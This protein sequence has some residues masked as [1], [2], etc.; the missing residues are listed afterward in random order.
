MALTVALGAFSDCQHL[1]IFVE[2]SRKPAK[3]RGK[4]CGGSC[5]SRKAAPEDVEDYTV[6][7]VA[8]GDALRDFEVLLVDLHLVPHLHRSK[9]RTFMNFLG[10]DVGR[11]H[12]RDAVLQNHDLILSV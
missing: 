11:R 12:L 3:T 1:E 8:L 7:V 5:R 9:R 2:A 4:S 6:A 10:L